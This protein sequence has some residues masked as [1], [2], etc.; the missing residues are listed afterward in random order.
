MINVLVIHD[1]FSDSHSLVRALERETFQVETAEDGKEA[2]Y[3]AAVFKPDVMI[4]DV[5]TPQ[6]E[7]Y[8]LYR[9]P[10]EI[11]KPGLLL[12]SERNSISDKVLGLER[13]ADVYM[14]K[15]F[16]IRELTA[17]VRALVRLKNRS[18]VST[19]QPKQ[20]MI[21]LGGLSIELVN[22]TVRLDGRELSLTPKEFD[23]L[24]VLARH[25]ERVYS[26]MALL[27]QVWD[28]PFDGGTRTVDTHV[29]RLRKKLGPRQGLIQ[30]VYGVGYKSKKLPS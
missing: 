2:L 6:Y 17:R 8:D 9:M 4:L 18:P 30:T 19:E 22:R 29:Q 24:T 15:P 16:D 5:A 11:E 1:E 28:I 12:L 14:T 25:P 20:E 10:Q 27:E 13:G 26:R 7:S 21:K 23:L 3:K